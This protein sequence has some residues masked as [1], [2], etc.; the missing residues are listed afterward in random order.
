MLGKRSSK[1]GT[2][3]LLNNRS[4]VVPNEVR[5]NQG[6]ASGNRF[7]GCTGLVSVGEGCEGSE[8]TGDLGGDA[9]AM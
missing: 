3:N 4:H 5:E 1:V 2:I 6:E 8:M 7:V 9:W